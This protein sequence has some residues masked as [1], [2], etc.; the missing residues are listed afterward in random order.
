[1]HP[2]AAHLLQ[3]FAYAHLPSDLQDFS[4]V[5]AK[6]AHAIDQRVEDGPE[7]TAALRKLLESKD[8][9]VRAMLSRSGAELADYVG[10]L[11]AELLEHQATLEGSSS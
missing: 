11:R 7:K 3:F 1:M 9:A 4:R 8:A 5:F 2:S 6:L 10:D